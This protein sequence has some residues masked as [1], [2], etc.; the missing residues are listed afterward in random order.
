MIHKLMHSNTV[1]IVYQF[2]YNISINGMIGSGITSSRD[3][4]INN[5]VFAMR[6]DTNHNYTGCSEITIW[7]GF[8]DNLYK[9][10]YNRHSFIIILSKRFRNKHCNVF[11]VQ[12]QLILFTILDLIGKLVTVCKN[13][14]IV[15]YFMY[16]RFHHLIIQYECWL[17]IT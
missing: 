2:D 11:A 6:C 4:H 14:F 12:I 10:Q 5:H 13:E 16:D 9:L 15:G 1:I 8:M 7:H 3:K 17:I